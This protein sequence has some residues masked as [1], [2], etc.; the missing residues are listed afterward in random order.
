MDGPR[1][2]DASRT[3]SGEKKGL[4]NLGSG[5]PPVLSSGRAVSLGVCPDISKN[6]QE[7]ACPLLTSNTLPSHPS[8]F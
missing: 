2:K 4:D 6:Q 3:W 5:S 8:G 1:G 7:R